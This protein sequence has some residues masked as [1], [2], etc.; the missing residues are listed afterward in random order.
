MKKT[1]R[2]RNNQTT[3]K[4]KI[5]GNGQA[6]T[7]RLTEKTAIQYLLRTDFPTFARKVFSTITGETLSRDRYVEVLHQAAMDVYEGSKRRL[8]LSL[9]PRHGKTSVFTV[10]LAAWEL[11]NRPSGKI[12]VISYSEDLARFIADQVRDVLSADWFAEAFPTRIREG[13]NRSMDFTTT[14]GG[15]VYASHLGRGITGRGA[16]LILVDDPF[17]IKDAQFPDRLVDGN[18]AFD[19]IVRHRLNH[20]AKGRIAVIAHRIHPQDLVAHLLAEGGWHHVKLPLIAERDTLCDTPTGSWFRRKG[21]L[22]REGEFTEAEID[23]M[24]RRQTVPD[25]ETLQQQAP[26]DEALWQISP[27]HF[28]VFEVVPA[29]AGGHVISIDTA[30]VLGARNSNSAAQV[31]R[32]S[33]AGHFLVDQFCAQVTHGELEVQVRRLINCYRPAVVLIEAAGTGMALAA[34]LSQRARREGFLV[35]MIPTGNRS[36]IARFAEIVSIIKAGMVH[37]PAPAP[38]RME[39][40]D[41]LV[42]FPGSPKDDQADATAQYLQW[43]KSHT[44]VAIRPSRDVG[45]AKNERGMT[46]SRG[47]TSPASLLGPRGHFFARHGSE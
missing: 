14:P 9:P 39:Y 23:A 44:A 22:L 28:R 46:I 45:F 36:K 10:A 47:T 26:P 41:Q 20:Q 16:D 40:V 29:G 3:K 11:A 24:R 4:A 30:S 27:D 15:G 18:N 32:S 25:F 5:K 2:S 33:A 37:L 21:E 12:I 34:N 35:E 7:A 42:T 43:Q 17:D 6:K 31:W 19:S 13:R 38:W 8:L 1:K